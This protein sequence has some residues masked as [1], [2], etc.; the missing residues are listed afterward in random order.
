MQQVKLMFLFLLV[1]LLAPCTSNA[2]LIKKNK[3]TLKVFTL[4][5]WLLEIP[6]FAYEISQKT[7]ERLS[8][9]P[10]F[11]KKLDAEVILLQEV[12]NF[13]HFLFIDQQLSNKGYH[14]CFVKADSIT[15]LGSGLAIFSKYPLL[16]KSCILKVFSTF[17]MIEEFFVSKGVLTV[18]IQHHRLGIIN[19]FNTH[20]GSVEVN[21]FGVANISHG[22]SRNGQA[23][24]LI[25]F[26]KT[27]TK[28]EDLVIL[29]G[30]F[31]FHEF[32]IFPPQEKTSLIT[33]TTG[34][35]LIVESLGL[36]DTYRK[37]HYKQDQVG[38]LGSTYAGLNDYLKKSHNSELPGF[39]YDYIFLRPHQNLTVKNSKVINKLNGF[40]LQISDHF[41][42]LTEFLY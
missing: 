28:K 6:P 11:L 4:N 38:Y 8:K 3:G 34:Y 1:A 40:D 35:S 37:S 14:S 5:S 29:A 41:G 25:S 33:K 15:N 32:I 27:Q 20:L 42:V 30:D 7:D 22:K 12:W 18:K 9:L 10:T 17:T 39:R 16:E 36:L 13:K 2:A 24:E 19:L 26:V 23:S 21:E 31:N